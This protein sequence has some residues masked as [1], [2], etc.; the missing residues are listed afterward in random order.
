MGCEARTAPFL[1]RDAGP[2]LHPTWPHHQPASL[3]G[4]RQPPHL[5]RRHF[6]VPDVAQH[7]VCAADGDI[8]IAEPIARL[9]ALRAVL[10]LPAPALQGLPDQVDGEEA[11]AGG[12]AGVAGAGGAIGSVGPRG[13]LH[14]IAWVPSL[15]T[16]SRNPVCV[17][18][19]HWVAWVGCWEGDGG[20]EGAGRVGE[21]RGNAAAPAAARGVRAES[22]G[23]GLLPR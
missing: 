19:V 20:E 5:L 3:C 16:T 17:R 21:R 8:I 6:S 18:W 7:V 22:R 4:G 2:P 23:R 13:A 1:F 9:G 15:T 11:G 10:P 14:R 12:A